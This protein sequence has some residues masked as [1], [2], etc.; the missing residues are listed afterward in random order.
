[1][2][3]KR[4]VTL[5]DINGNICYPKT[6]A[7]N[8]LGFAETLEK[9]EKITTEMEEWESETSEI[10]KDVE[11][12]LAIAQGAQISKSFNDYQTMVR[13]LNNDSGETYKI[14]DNIYIHT[15]E[16]P[17]LWIAY[18][19]SGKKEYFYT[20]DE[21]LVEALKSDTAGLQIGHYYV[22][23]LETSKVNLEEYVPSARKIGDLSLKQDI[24]N[25][26]LGQI[27]TSAL[28]RGGSWCASLIPWLTSYCGSK[29]QETANTT[30]IEKLQTREKSWKR[31]RS[32]VVPGVDSIGQILDGVTFKGTSENGIKS[33]EFD[34]DENGNA[35]KGNG[36]TAIHIKFDTKGGLTYINQGFLRFN[37]QTVQYIT[38]IKPKTDTT[39]ILEESICGQSL[40]PS[41][42]IS[43]TQYNHTRMSVGKEVENVRILGFEDTSVLGEG[44][45]LIFWAYGYWE[46]ES[47]VA[48]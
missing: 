13:V 38:S 44:A 35:L 7:S 10:K 22:C 25:N 47:E 30:A 19:T 9:A 46:D 28:V 18:V 29:N 2:G 45:E 15:L 41:N 39:Y 34:T 3:N 36:I 1:M 17:D 5:R 4:N 24:D 12:A 31:I 14:G 37:E 27:V 21:D 32:V 11:N 16:V 33:L 48:E 20:C 26:A 42:N 6:T 40:S 43:I 8:V 23:P